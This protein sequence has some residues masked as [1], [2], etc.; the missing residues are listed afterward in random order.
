MSVHSIRSLNVL[1]CCAG[2]LALTGC[3]TSHLN[4]DTEHNQSLFTAAVNELVGEYIASSETLDATGKTGLMPEITIREHN[5]FIVDINAKKCEYFIDARF[6][7]TKDVVEDVMLSVVFR[8]T[9]TNGETHELSEFT[10]D[11]SE[12]LRLGMA[13]VQNGKR[14]D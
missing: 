3:G 11:Q 9:G 2:A 12:G 6:P 4:C 8:S 5:Q 14:A 7:H 1:L 10:I 13:A